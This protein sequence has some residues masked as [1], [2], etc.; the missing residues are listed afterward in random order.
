MLVCLVDSNYIEG[1]Q[2]GD[3][4]CEQ[5]LNMGNILVKGGIIQGMVNMFNFI[6]DVCFVGKRVIKVGQGQIC[7]VCEGNG[8]GNK[9]IN[10]EVVN[11]W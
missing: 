3:G 10:L 5:V 6:F 2:G 4:M 8:Y 1:Y 11:V 7:I 9:D